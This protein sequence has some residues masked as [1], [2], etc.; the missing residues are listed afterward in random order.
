LWPVGPLI[1][2]NDEQ[3][4]AVYVRGNPSPN[5]NAKI[6]FW[7]EIVPVGQISSI[8]FT[9]LKGPDGKNHV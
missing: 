6:H 3:N 4:S 9:A 8:G 1:F 7:W 5:G 2:F